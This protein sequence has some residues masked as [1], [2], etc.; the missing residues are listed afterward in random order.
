MREFC[1]F[2]EWGLLQTIKADRLSVDEYGLTFYRVVS[3]SETGRISRDVVAFF[4]ED[5]F[6]Y[7]VEVQV[8]SDES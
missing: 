5:S 1:V 6:R 8:E 2:G 3:D 4:T 7:F